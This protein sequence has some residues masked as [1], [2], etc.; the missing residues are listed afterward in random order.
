MKHSIVGA[1]LLPALLLGSLPAQAANHYVRAGA[2]GTATGNDW[3]NACPD[4]VGACAPATM[5]RGDTYYVAD[6]SYASRTFNKAASGN[7]LIAI[8]KATLA[9]HGS[10]SG[11]LSSYGDGQAVFKSVLIFASDDWLL[12]GATRDE[13]NPPLS[14]FKTAAYGF[15]ITN[16]DNSAQTQLKLGAG[17]DNFT[18]KQV[19]VQGRSGP[20]DGA[21]RRY[22]IDCQS[23]GT[24]TNL[25]FSRNLTTDSNQWYFLRDTNHSVIEY[26]AGDRL[27]GDGNNH[28]DAINVYFTAEDVTIRWGVAR[29]A[30]T[31]GCTGMIPVADSRGTSTP[32]LVKLYGNL[33]YDYGST[34]GTMGFLGNTANGGNCT[35]CVIA[36][37][38]FID[39]GAEYAATWGLQFPDGSGNLHRNNI[40]F[41]TRSQ[42]PSFNLG[43]NATN[44][45][46]AFG[47]T[48]ASTGTGA[49]VGVPS[50][51]FVD[52]AGKNFRLSAATACGL[53][54][55][56][57]YDR[58][59]FGNTRGADGCW[60]RG[61]FEFGKTTPARLAPP[62]NLRLR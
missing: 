25:L 6:G 54:L 45:H 56:P 32:P 26:W 21:E 57:P 42:I 7:L 23:G 11:W 46:N 58:D 55:G 59:M 12:D 38:T 48:T 52:F 19:W 8:K 28:G 43:A 62:E 2:S 40:W 22:A 1:A 34:D 36:N 20:F 41:E 24:A 53:A 35:N 47:P 5:V 50:T 44:T 18:M 4:F 14:W 39:G 49:Q 61:A 17:L 30:C 31:E 51:I 29:N 9:D 27:T 3:T 13:S 16:N 33:F 60:D 37:N 10:D 15:A